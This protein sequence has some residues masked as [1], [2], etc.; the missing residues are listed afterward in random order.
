M[1]GFVGF[2]NS[3]KINHEYAKNSLQIMT[4]SLIHRGPDAS[5]T[6]SDIENNLY[7]GHRRLSILD[8]SDGGL[9]PM[10]S[11]SGNLV[12]VFNGEIYNH[13]DL[14]AQLEKESQLTAWDS[15]SDTETLLAAFEHWGIQET[16]PRLRGMFAIALWDKLN[17]N[18]YLIREFFNKNTL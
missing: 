11:K 7:L 14:R 2:F 9:Q 17:D 1:C 5:G 13:N 10:K 3:E 4:D 12:I 16:L 8:T 15:S 18:F 6:F